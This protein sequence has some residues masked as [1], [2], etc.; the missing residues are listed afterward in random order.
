MP[1]IEAKPAIRGVV[2]TTWR[3]LNMNMSMTGGHHNTA[4]VLRNSGSSS[5]VVTQRVTR[6][7]P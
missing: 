7:L 5:R 3:V 2:L 1:W 6:N 4:V